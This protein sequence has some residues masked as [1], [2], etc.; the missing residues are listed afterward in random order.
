M[1][2]EARARACFLFACSFMRSEAVK[3]KMGSPDEVSWQAMSPRR[4]VEGRPSSSRLGKA[5]A[6]IPEGYINST[7]TGIYC[8]LPDRLLSR[9][10]P[11]ARLGGVSAAAHDDDDDD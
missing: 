10:G 3:T 4:L 7:A 9:S 2:S 11:V 8:A 1:P 6:F 5:V